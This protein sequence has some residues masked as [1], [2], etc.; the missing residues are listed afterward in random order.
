M[1]ES[2]KQEGGRKENGQVIVILSPSARESE[3]VEGER[4]MLH[5][6]LTLLA[7]SG[8]PEQDTILPECALRRL[9]F[10]YSKG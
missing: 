5:L 7:P 8:I 10:S 1:S 4:R 9:I 3:E 2:R 6:P